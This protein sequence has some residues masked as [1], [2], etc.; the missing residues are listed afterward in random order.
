MGK[1]NITRLLWQARRRLVT[2]PWMVHAAVVVLCLSAFYYAVTVRSEQRALQEL[3]ARAAAP[4]S[5]ESEQAERDGTP[6]TQLTR[7]YAALPAESDRHQLLHALYQAATRHGLALE[8]GVYRPARE[9]SGRLQKLEITYP[10]RGSYA[11][12]RG[13]LLEAS[14]YNGLA[15]EGMSFKRR[16]NGDHLEGEMRFT[17]FTRGEG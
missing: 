8:E 12:L 10:V 6:Q 9:D 14:A 11:Q 1:V 13:F 7:F 3:V 2:W 16:D 5:V 15:L 4:R 17:L